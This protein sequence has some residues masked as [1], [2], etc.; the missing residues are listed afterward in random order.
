MTITQSTRQ[1]S[2]NAK[3]P[4]GYEEGGQVKLLSNGQAEEG[5]YM[6]IGE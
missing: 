6:E 1:H 2:N 5:K 3:H 4:K